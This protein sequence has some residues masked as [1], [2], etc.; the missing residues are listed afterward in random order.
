MST[1]KKKKPRPW[2]KPEEDIPDVIWGGQKN[3]VGFPIPDFGSG[4][5]GPSAGIPAPSI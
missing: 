2:D 3:G 5:N 1:E 4:T